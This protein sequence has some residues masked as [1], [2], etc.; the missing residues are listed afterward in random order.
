LHEGRGCGW[1]VL[2][3]APIW[4]WGLVVAVGGCL[5]FL[6]LT[7]GGYYLPMASPH[8]HWS[9]PCWWWP[10]ITGGISPSPSI[11]GPIVIGT[12]QV[13]L[14]FLHSPPMSQLAASLCSLE[15]HLGWAGVHPISAGGPPIIA[16]PSYLCRNN[17]KLVKEN[18]KRTREKTSIWARGAIPPCH[19]PL[20]ICTG[21]LPVHL[22]IPIPIPVVDPHP[23]PVGCRATGQAGMGRPPSPVL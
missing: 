22:S 6:A 21:N 10:L 5:W 11:A 15:T 2:L 19:P 12:P 17:V 13:L 1:M 4:H 3:V 8:H 16:F 23:Q 14:L 7:G 18:N 9:C 20:G